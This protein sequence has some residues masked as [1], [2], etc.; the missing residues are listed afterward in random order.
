MVYMF[1][2]TEIYVIKYV[3]RNSYAK[4]F[5]YVSQSKNNLKEYF[6]DTFGEEG[7]L[8]WLGTEHYVTKK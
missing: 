4:P 1:N 8:K 6:K 7:K 5:I 2:T 3:T